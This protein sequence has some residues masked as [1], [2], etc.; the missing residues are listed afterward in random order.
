M[1]KYCRREFNGMELNGMELKIICLMASDRN[2]GLVLKRNQDQLKKQRRRSRCGVRRGQQRDSFEQM[3]R[4]AKETKES[5][6]E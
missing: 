1:L 4:I 5:E 3:R 2:D 6:R